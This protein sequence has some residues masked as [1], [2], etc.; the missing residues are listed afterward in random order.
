MDNQGG[1][2]SSFQLKSFSTGSRFLFFYLCQKLSSVYCLRDG[3]DLSLLQP[4]AFFCLWINLMA[5]TFN[6][7]ESLSSTDDLTQHSKQSK[8]QKGKVKANQCSTIKLQLLANP[9][10]SSKSMASCQSYLLPHWMHCNCNCLNLQ[11]WC[12]WTTP[13]PPMGSTCWVFNLLSSFLSRSLSSMGTSSLVTNEI[14][15]KLPSATSWL[16]LE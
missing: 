5:S 11:S 16:E 7:D 4:K 12:W 9:T 1:F 3:D 2:A 13:P 6:S 15:N 14:V 8:L 10:M